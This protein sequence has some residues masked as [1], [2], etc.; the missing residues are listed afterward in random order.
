MPLSVAVV[1]GD[2]GGLVEPLS[3]AVVNGD[4]VGG[5][6]APLSVAVVGGDEGCLVAPRPVL[7]VGEE[8]EP[9]EPAAPDEDGSIPTRHHLG[10]TV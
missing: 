1:D 7:E 4:Q 5:L 10:I 8:D 9:E 2:E 3:V 6:V